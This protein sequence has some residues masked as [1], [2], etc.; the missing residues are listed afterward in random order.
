MWLAIVGG[1]WNN[2]GSNFINMLAVI[3]NEMQRIMI[4]GIDISH[5]VIII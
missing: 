4:K 5:Q 1:N 3:K 2:V